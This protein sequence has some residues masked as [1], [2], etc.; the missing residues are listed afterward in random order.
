VIEARRRHSTL[1]KP[2]Q[3]PLKL[4]VTVDVELLAALDAGRQG[5]RSR[6]QAET[7]AASGEQCPD[8]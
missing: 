4:K 7:P 2:P 1:G 3:Q 5:R 8:R 6:S